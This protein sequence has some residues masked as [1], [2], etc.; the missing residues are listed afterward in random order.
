MFGSAIQIEI[1]LVREAQNWGTEVVIK[2]SWDG[3]QGSDEKRI[4][5][6]PLRRGMAVPSNQK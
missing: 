2:I 5:V 4:T 3:V 6:V 1:Q